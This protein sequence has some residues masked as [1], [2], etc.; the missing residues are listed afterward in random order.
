MIVGDAASMSRRFG[1]DRGAGGTQTAVF[2]LV[3]ARPDELIASLQGALPPGTVI[4][5][6]K[7]TGALVVTAGATALV[8]A[9]ALV[10]ALDRPAG[11]ATVTETIPLRNVRA[12]EAL[13]LLK[14]SVPDGALVADDRRNAVAATGNAELRAAV[15]ALLASVDAPGR[16]VMFE[17]RVADVQPIDDTE[18]V[19]LELGGTG[20]GTRRA[21]PVSLHADVALGDDQRAAQYADPARPC[22]DPRP[23]A[24]RNAEQSR[25]LA[26]DRR[27]VPRRERQPAD[28]LSVRADD[29]RRRAPARHTDDRRRRLDHRRAASRVQPDH[30]LQRKLSDHREPQ[31]RLVLARARRRDDRPR[32]ALPGRRLRD[33]HASFR[34]SAT[35]RSSA[36][37]FATASAPA[38][39]TRS[40][41]SSPRT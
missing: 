28:G 10:T 15:R 13:R 37:S 9:R 22:L 26:A 1:D 23:A 41:S 34:C 18:N 21:G 33:G 16:Q 30:R 5:G 12:S 40:S 35:C 36:P 11:G 17:V 6:D 8:R 27:A 39:K 3:Y 32:R 14:G 38:T 29:R 2:T 4:V 25:S 20:F 31:A 7:R 24:N 19:G